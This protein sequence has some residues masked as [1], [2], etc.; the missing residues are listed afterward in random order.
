MSHPCV[1][2][3]VGA[4]GDTLILWRK[5]GGGGGWVPCV[6]GPLVLEGDVHGFSRM[7]EDCG[8]IVAYGGRN[9]YVLRVD[10]MR[11]RLVF[12]E[13]CNVP[14][15]IL[16]VG[17]VVVADA[18]DSS[19]QSHDS[20]ADGHQLIVALAHNSAMRLSLADNL[21]KVCARVSASPTAVMY[22]CRIF[23]G[24]GSASE[25]SVFVFGTVDGLVQS[26]GSS[27][28]CVSGDCADCQNGEHRQDVSV[29]LACK[30]HKGVAFCVDVVRVLEG[31]DELTWTVCAADDRSVRVWCNGVER[32]AL[33][34]TDGRPWCVQWCQTLGMPGARCLVA[35]GEDGTLRWF[36]DPQREAPKDK[37]L[38]WSASRYACHGG[39][40]CLAECEGW[41]AVGGDDGSVSLW[42]SRL[43]MSAH[44]QPIC[45]PLPLQN[46]V[47]RAICMSGT[48]VLCVASGS[49][50]FVRSLSGSWVEQGG[51]LVTGAAGIHR[52]CR[53]PSGAWIPCHKDGSV[54]F[55][56][57]VVRRPLTSLH[58]AKAVGPWILL[59]SWSG[60]F[61][62][63]LIESGELLG[64]G[65]F[66]LQPKESVTACALTSSSP[67]CVAIGTS[68]GSLCIA[69]WKEDG[70]VLLLERFP[71]VHA[72]T[73]TDLCFLV[74]G[75]SRQRRL[76]SACRDGNVGDFVVDQAGVLKT[77][78]VARPRCV[79]A[80]ES[81]EEF[82]PCGDDRVV[83]QIQ[84]G[85][86]GALFCEMPANTPD[87]VIGFVPSLA[88]RA[89][90]A[91]VLNA[92]GCFCVSVVAGRALVEY[93][94]PFVNRACIPLQ[95]DVHC[96][97]VNVVR[98]SP[99]FKGF[100]TASD[101]GRWALW[102][103]QKMESPLFWRKSGQSLRAVTFTEDGGTVLLASPTDLYR[104]STTQ[105]LWLGTL[106]F[107][108][109]D[110]VTSSSRSMW[111]LTRAGQVWVGDSRGRVIQI[112]LLD[113]IAAQVEFEFKV[114]EFCLTDVY[115]DGLFLWIVSTRGELIH[116]NT[117]TGAFTV[118][119]VTKCS[120]GAVAG[121]GSRVMV[122]GDDGDK[123][124]CFD[125]DNLLAA[126]TPL[127]VGHF[128]SIVSLLV[129]PG[130]GGHTIVAVLSK[131]ETLTLWDD[132][133]VVGATLIGKHRVNVLN[134]NSMSAVLMD[135]DF[136]YRL[137]I[138]GGSGLTV[139]D[140][141]F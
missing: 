113:D 19:S 55:G 114:S 99:S 101:D 63:C 5:M 75:A 125:G 39:V 71:R 51:K 129:L 117:E 100:V 22:S 9:L 43:A 139:V 46:T 62:V 80:V 119:R 15:W 16:D 7:C 28:G 136:T 10:E 8:M 116:F 135:D 72:K 33:W 78:S 44:E 11:E 126:P 26:W 32:H 6:G 127:R 40:R 132:D 91:S 27:L 128:S 88:P 79:S 24:G 18:V 35:G 109:A 54:R 138:V 120:L 90:V 52:L 123:V 47:V 118:R 37:A 133:G 92:H 14:D 4:F 48:A 57:S 25:K 89:L 86:G 64:Q 94:W 60:T 74:G 131:D 2:M 84:I 34:M 107:V 104:Y 82:I 134:P 1:G 102:A 31:N 103:A 61:A 121:H 122:A 105:G 13:A 67:H 137:T 69:W 140:F 93:Q 50:L 36:A 141:R 130:R 58:L 98:S 41:V 77:C 65:A 106:S 70:V 68:D 56:D 96:A 30:G 108:V 17:L 45:H 49:S 66:S 87:S 59:V 76:L 81:V 42:N 97:I 111:C 83:A 112:R 12:I 95:R 110:A 21:P 124:L 23:G 20:C 29:G 3:V 115:D 85:G 38:Q 53:A 73:V